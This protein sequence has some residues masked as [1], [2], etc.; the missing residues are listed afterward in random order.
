MRLRSSLWL[1]SPP[2]EPTREVQPAE[3][4]EPPAGEQALVSWLL[5]HQAVARISKWAVLPSVR[6]HC[7]VL[8]LK[9]VRFAERAWLH[10]P[11]NVVQETSWGR[12]GATDITWDSWR[13][14]VAWSPHQTAAGSAGH[15]REPH[16][17]PSL[18][19]PTLSCALTPQSSFS[20]LVIRI[21][22]LE[23]TVGLGWGTVEWWLLFFSSDNVAL[24]ALQPGCL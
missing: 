23:A 15:R 11:L 18:W 8:F 22:P 24:A 19:T 6:F 13:V 17:W 12:P 14:Q 20:R 3:R 7:S 5:W 1:H 4:K 10:S 9:G 21:K 2:L 16:R